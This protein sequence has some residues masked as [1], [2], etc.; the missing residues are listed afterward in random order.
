MNKLSQQF[1]AA[2]RTIGA[3]SAI[4]AFALGLPLLGQETPAVSSSKDSSSGSV[5]TPS[6]T[7]NDKEPGRVYG[8]YRITQS[9]TFGGRIA[10]FSGNQSLWS[11]FINVRSG[12]RLLEN[13]FDMR[14]VVRQGTLFDELSF[15]TFGFG[16]DPNNLTKVRLAKYRWYR[17]DA[18]FRRDRNYWDYDLLANP[19][20]PPTSNPSVPLLQSPH[21]FAT[22]R[23]LYDYTLTIRPESDFRVRLGYSRNSNAGPSFSSIKEG[24]EAQI[25]QNWRNTVNNYQMGADWKFARRTSLSYDQFLSFFKGDTDWQLAANPYTLSN[26]TAVDLGLPFNTAAS[27]PCATP[28]LAGGVANPACNGFLAYNRKN[29]V[30]GS[31]PTEQLT[32]HS[33]YV[34]WLDVTARFNY[35]AGDSNVA[36]SNEFYQGLST[37]TRERQTLWTGPAGNTRV[38]VSA[39]LGVTIR[40]NDKFRILNSF[41]WWDNRLPGRWSST[42]SSLFG[43]S[44][45]VAPNVFSPAACPPPYT[46]ATCPQ[47]STNSGPD[48]SVNLYAN[49]FGQDTKTE[50]IDL[51]YDFNRRVGGR[52]GYRYRNRN[53][54]ER[55][56]SSLDQIFYPNNVRR[57][58]CADLTV[59]LNPDGSCEVVTED[60]EDAVARINEHTGLAGLWLRPDDHWDI[61]FDL[62][63]LTADTAFTRISPRRQQ[64][65]RTRVNYSPRPWARFSVSLDLL[66]RRNTTADVNHQLHNRNY[67]V[68]AVFMPEHGR[69]GLDL[70]YD[71]TEYY[72]ATNICYVATPAPAGTPSCGAPFLLGNAFYG[73]DNNFGQFSAFLKPV[74]N[75][76][77]KAGYTVTRSDGNNLLLNPLAPIGPLRTWWQRPIAGLEYAFHP[78]WTGIFDYNFNN[79]REYSD[80]GPTAARNF[81][82]NIVTLALRYA[83]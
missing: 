39:N 55:S 65:F 54:T 27:Q 66:K 41:R 46:A 47:H 82:G 29:D 15:H 77:V 24:T 21:L 3:G 61:R 5:D 20:N 34:K 68:S 44:M 1:L 4:L 32:L 19:L 40:V 60:G 76:T 78:N 64:L 12:P 67:G 35:T 8:N 79:Y 18:Q 53:I 69:W 70:S 42:Q 23:R 30:R 37:R 62:E 7:N 57:G 28:L 2:V 73:L 51:V 75:L 59:P 31:F 63:F 52:L 25:F 80:P 43:S 17:F 6:S 10:D 11:T 13:N 26:G 9:I 45:L 36:N 71:F 58:A 22:V 83:F 50:Q 56:F 72:S 33:N 38:N 74:K 16:G 48:A 81:R 49:Y 14:S